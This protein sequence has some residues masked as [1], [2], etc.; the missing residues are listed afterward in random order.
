MSERCDSL[1]E[2]LCDRG[3]NPLGDSEFASKL[4]TAGRGN[5]YRLEETDGMVFGDFDLPLVREFQKVGANTLEHRDITSESYPL[6][7]AEYYSR[8]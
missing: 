5:I 1:L 6:P 2:D 8:L 7:T 3:L 4:Q